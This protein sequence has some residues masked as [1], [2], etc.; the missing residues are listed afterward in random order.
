MNEEGER[1][2]QNL[3][4]DGGI[5]LAAGRGTKRD[6]E[7]G[8]A[9]GRIGKRAKRARQQGAVVLLV[10]AVVVALIADQIRDLLNETVQPEKQRRTTNNFGSINR[11]PSV[12]T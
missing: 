2:L 9:G 6:R 5:A 8:R 1:V 11:S 3:L 12:H 10:H 7:V 4:E